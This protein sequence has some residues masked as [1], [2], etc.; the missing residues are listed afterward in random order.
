MGTVMSASSGDDY[1]VNWEYGVGWKSPEVFD[2][3][4]QFTQQLNAIPSDWVRYFIRL[5]E[6]VERHPKFTDLI[7]R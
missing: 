3:A 6:R 7:D 5:V 4:Y 2:D 1:P